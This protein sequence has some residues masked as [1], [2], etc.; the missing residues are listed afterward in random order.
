MLKE[1]LPAAARVAVLFNPLNLAE[2][3]YA[4][5]LK[6]EAP[7][8]GLSP[9]LVEVESEAAFSQ[10]FKTIEVARPDALYVIQAVFALTHRAR[11]MEFANGRKLPVVSGLDDFVEAGGLMSYHPNR[12]EVFLVAATHAAKILEG[13]KPADLPVHQA[14]VFEMVIN[15]KAAKALG[16]KIPPAILVRADRVIE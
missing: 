6:A 8:L 12:S 2:L 7:K 11:I 1:V 4:A 9:Q 15:M 10:A 14:S 16:I 13:A 5:A 3:Q